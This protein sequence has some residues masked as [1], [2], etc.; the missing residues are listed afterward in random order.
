M[1]NP[2]F[3]NTTTLHITSVHCSYY[4]SHHYSY[5]TLS[6]AGLYQILCFQTQGGAWHRSKC[7]HNHSTH[8]KRTLLLLLF[9]SLFL[10]YTFNGRSLPNPVFPNTRRYLASQYLSSKLYRSDVPVGLNHWALAVTMCRGT[11]PPPW[12]P[13][14]PWQPSGG[15]SSV[16][17]F[18]ASAVWDFPVQGWPFFSQI[19]LSRS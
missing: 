18:V 12:Q 13:W 9:S 7:R 5:P 19:F 4:S 14:E 16:L 15:G 6:T 10:S 3:P 11:E 17:G 2:V 1:P 8:D